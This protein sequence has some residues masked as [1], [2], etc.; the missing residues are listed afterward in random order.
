MGSRSPGG[1]YTYLTNWLKEQSKGPLEFPKGL[2]KSV[3]D[4]SQK[5]GK[6]YLISGTN[7]IP[8]SVITSHLWITLDKGNDIQNDVKFSPSEL[9]LGKTLTENQSKELLENLTKPSERFRETR[10]TFLSECITIV[11]AQISH[12]LHEYLIDERLKQLEVIA[13][14]KVCTWCKQTTN[15]LEQRI[16][17]ICGGKLVREASKDNEEHINI[18]PYASFVKQE[19]SIPHIECMAGEPDFLNPSGYENVIIVLQAI[20]KRAGIKHYGSGTREW[21]FVECDGLPYNIIRDVIIN[22]LRCEKCEKFFYGI[23]SFQDDLCFILKS[24]NPR[25]EFC[26]LVPVS[27]LLHQE[28][29]LGK[30]FVKLNWDIFVRTVGMSLGFNSPKAQEYLKKGSD[31]HK[32][33]HLLEIMYGAITLELLVPYVKEFKQQQKTATCDGYW[34]WSQDVKDPNYCYL[35]TAVLTHLHALMMLRAGD[36]IHSK[37]NL[38]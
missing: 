32:L 8:T 6:T 37:I 20:G 34:L 18:E 30:A 17:R 7:T 5:V 36:Y 29:N 3:F 23:N 28:M 33:W 1:A 14:R 4:N 16:C 10:N 12:E 31:H 38:F 2:V 21:L 19:N 25:F 9:M 35:Q 26:W 24:I 11:N 13:A 27:G 15:Q 22:V